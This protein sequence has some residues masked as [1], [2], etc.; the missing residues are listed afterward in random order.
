MPYLLKNLPFF[1]R[2]EPY[3]LEP[4][5]QGRYVTILPRQIPVRIS[6]KAS[7][8][9]GEFPSAFSFP[10]VF[11]TG[12]NGTLLI[13]S[14]HLRNW[15]HLS[16]PQFSEHGGH[17]AA[18]LQL[19]IRGMPALV[20]D[21]TI[22]I[23]PNES[24]SWIRGKGEAHRVAHGGVFVV[25]SEPPEPNSEPELRLPLLGM[26]ALEQPGKKSRLEIDFSARRVQL[27]V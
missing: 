23:H 6:L 9:H 10:A 26:R 20:H 17:S 8:S 13:S 12:F 2:P 21:S 14:Y 16:P 27:R 18:G 1:N 4:A 25:Q 19:R 11:D 22:W 3:F 7:A 24:D 15:A 5:G